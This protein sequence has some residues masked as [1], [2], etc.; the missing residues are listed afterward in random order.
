MNE[1]QGSTEVAPEVLA[2]F[3]HYLRFVSRDPAKNRARFYLFSWQ[4]ALDG[5]TALVCTWGRLGTWRCRSRSPGSLCCLHFQVPQIRASMIG[6]TCRM[7]VCC[8]RPTPGRSIA[9][10]PA[11][12]RIGAGRVQDNQVLNVPETC[13]R[14]DASE[15]TARIRRLHDRPHGGERE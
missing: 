5:E 2:R 11:G 10:C 15:V 7:I 9:R 13:P 14:G 12:S 1:D 3:Q 8:V 6:D 4:V